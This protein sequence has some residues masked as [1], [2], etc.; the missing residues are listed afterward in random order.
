MLAVS[1]EQLDSRG[2]Q[3]MD[4]TA[5]FGKGMTASDALIIGLKSDQCCQFGFS[6]L[7]R[8]RQNVAVHREAIRLKPLPERVPDIDG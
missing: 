4:S 3:R 8:Q 7:P 2:S 1:G 5:R 6:C